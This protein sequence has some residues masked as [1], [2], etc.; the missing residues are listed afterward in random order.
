M[1]RSRGNGDALILLEGLKSGDTIEFVSYNSIPSLPSLTQNTLRVRL[2][3]SVCKER[4]FEKIVSNRIPPP[5]VIVRVSHMAV[6]RSKLSR[7]S[8][9]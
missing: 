5:A 8:T 7:M 1:L 2:R 9:V 4:T 3:V 6:P